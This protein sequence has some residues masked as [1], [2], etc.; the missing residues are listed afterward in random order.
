MEQPTEQPVDDEYDACLQ[1]SDSDDACL[2]DADSDDACLQDSD[3][4]DEYVLMA[5]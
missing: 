1:D 5:A 4:D 3:G 2:Q